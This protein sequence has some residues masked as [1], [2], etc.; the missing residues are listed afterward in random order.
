MKPDWSCAPEWANYVVMNH[1]GS[2]YWFEFEPTYNSK[3]GFWQRGF[4]E[5]VGRNEVVKNIIRPEDSKM[6]R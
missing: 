3:N 4:Y 2:W 6:V 1:D 5:K